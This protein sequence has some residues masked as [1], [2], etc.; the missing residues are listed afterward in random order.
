LGHCH[1]EVTAAVN[2]QAGTLVHV[3]NLFKNQLAP[4]LA[5]EI[6]RLISEGVERVSGASARGKVFFSNSGSE[7]NECAIKLARKRS[8]KSGTGRYLIVS[9]EGGFHGRT[10]GSLS[11]T[12]QPL[13]QI[14]F[15][16]L[17]QGFVQ[18]PIGDSDA[19]T[20]E[21]RNGHLGAVIIEPVQGETGVIEVPG[22][23]VMKAR[24]LCDEQD[25]LLIL[26]EVQ[27]GFGRTGKWFGF[28]H[29][30][31]VP[32][33]VTL[34]KSLGNGMPIGACWAIEDAAEAFVPGDHGTTF[35][36]QPLACSAALATLKIIEDN[37]LV[38]RAAIAG[39]RLASQLRAMEGVKQVR[40]AGLLIGIGLDQSLNAKAIT[41]K[42]LELGLIVN[43]IGESTIRIAPALIASDA[44]LDEGVSILDTAIRMH[45]S[46]DSKVVNAI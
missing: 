29:H 43:A 38:G 31:V 28:E 33:V 35:G 17:P 14:P 12:G 26:D 42:A 37:G 1:P 23:F 44:E 15:G 25:A 6:D 34:A 41:Q 45:V 8:G 46:A 19:L 32:D 16:P 30:G 5:A 27:T 21:C 36:G 40:G 7:A 24:E 39:N 3:S 4:R 13:K 20:K 22:E 10:L 18:V 9:A 11:A 2:L